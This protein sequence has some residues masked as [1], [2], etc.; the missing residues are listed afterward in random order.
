MLLND[1]LQHGWMTAV[2][3]NRIWV[4]YCNWTTYANPQATGFGAVNKWFGAD[5]IELFEPL[6]KVFPSQNGL[7]PG[8][9]FRFVRIRAEEDM[10]S[11][12]FQP[13][14]F[15]GG[16]KFFVHDD[17]CRLTLI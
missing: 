16:L 8:T 1:P 12:G 14:F 2:I 17:V 6:F 13:Q 4:N 9:A 11:V 5:E 15:G 3:P 10:A 7:L